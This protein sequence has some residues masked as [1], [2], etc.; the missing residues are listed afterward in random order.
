MD[1]WS[2]EQREPRSEVEWHSVLQTKSLDEELDPGHLL[3]WLPVVES[4]RAHSV[5]RGTRIGRSNR[6]HGC[7]CHRFSFFLLLSFY[8][9]QGRGCLGEHAAETPLPPL[10][11]WQTRTT[12]PGERKRGGDVH[13]QN[14]PLGTSVDTPSEL[15]LASSW[16]WLAALKAEWNG[17][18][19]HLRNFLPW[20]HWSSIWSRRNARGS[21]P[22]GSEVPAHPSTGIAGW[23]P[24]TTAPRDALYSLREDD[25]QSGADEER[26]PDV[27]T[28]SS[29]M[30]FHEDR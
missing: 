21:C 25:R 9:L 29:C 8:P 20:S 2:T 26:G 28:F 12:G 5:V 30:S 14:V 23:E 19:K 6:K 1:R 7:S 4:R 15:T 22:T 24:S 3:S 13:G 16:R 18:R 10:A 27:K 11:L 17:R